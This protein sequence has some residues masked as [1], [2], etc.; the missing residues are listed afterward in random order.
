MA[1]ES[2][3]QS[4][5]DALQMRWWLAAA[6][7]GLGLVIL[8]VAYYPTFASMVAIWQRSDTFAHGFLIVPIVLFLLYLKRDE[9]RHLAPEP[10]WWAMV[11]LLGLSLVWVAGE[12]VDVISVRQFAAVL[13]IPALFW[14]VLGSAITWRLQFPLAYLLFAVPFGEFMVEPMM[15]WTADFT[16]AA[17]QWSGIPI[18]RDGLNFE[19]PTGRWSVVEACSGVR[20]LMASVAVGTLYAFLIYRSPWRRVAFVG[21][22]ILVP[23]VA[24]WM[25]AYGIVMIGHLSDMRLAAG[26]DHLVYGWVFFGVIIFLMF[27]IGA[28]WREDHLDDQ[29][30]RK[31]ARPAARTHPAI[32]R[33][34]TAAVFAGALASAAPLYAAWMNQRDLGPVTGLGEGPLAPDGWHAAEEQDLAWTPGYR[35]A[36]DGRG[37]LVQ[38]EGGNDPVGAHVLFYRGQARH[39]SMVG[40]ANTLAGRDRAE[41]W[42]QTRRGRTAFDEFPDAQR[43]LLEGPGQQQLVVWRWYWVDGR[44]TTS[45]HEVKAREALNR[46][47]GQRDDA[48]LIVL[49]APYG[50]DPDPAEERLRDYAEAVLPDVL[51]RLAE[52]NQR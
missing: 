13:M 7:L 36:R 32:R 35:F 40:W 27:L 14:L 52:V 41:D 33:F 11:P 16:V 25:R 18:Y 29:T 2:R 38:P 39:G 8:G 43:F 24:N 15:I 26:V 46:L 31:P 50:F 47:L 19:L 20:Y 1:S 48:A 44:L 12:L 34:V 17:V 45:P 21:V 42:S 4:M 28:I 49:Y 51:D 37:G 9:V 30:Q 6:A 23:I 22:A 5:P 3:T 10:T